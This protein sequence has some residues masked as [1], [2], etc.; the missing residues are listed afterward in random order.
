MAQGFQLSNQANFPS[1]G[2]APSAMDGGPPSEED[3]SASFNTVPPPV[4]EEQQSL[5]EGP[6]GHLGSENELNMFAGSEQE[7]EEPGP[8]EDSNNEGKIRDNRI[9][10]V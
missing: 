9:I 2:L 6:Q 7:E 1:E 3:M 5:Q 10:V 4:S 8:S